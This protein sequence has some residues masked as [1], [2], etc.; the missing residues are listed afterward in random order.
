MAYTTI[1]KSSSFQ[2][3]KLYAGNGGTQTISGVGFQPNL[4]WF[5]NRSEA[6]DHALYDTVRGAYWTIQTNTNSTQ[7]ANDGLTSWTSD[8]FNIGNVNNTNKNGNNIVAWNWKAGTTSGLSGGTITPTSYSIN[9]T[10][11]FGIYKYTG[12]NTSG[13]TI[14]HGLG[15]VPTLIFIKRYEST[16]GSWQVLGNGFGQPGPNSY[17]I[18]NSTDGFASNA[19]RWNNT[20]PTTSLFSL[21]NSAEV[22]ASGG[23][24]IAYVWCNVSGYFKSG[25]YQG[26]GN[27]DG[28]FVYTGGSPTFTIMRPNI[29]GKNWYMWDDKRN[30]YNGS[31]K[32]NYPNTNGAEGDIST[33]VNMLSNGFK[34][35]TTDN[36]FNGLGNSYQYWCWMQTLVGTNNVPATAR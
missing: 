1:N 5:K 15:A 27:A 3:T 14:S 24:Y 6:F 26:N 35:I 22:N 18:L 20:A 34:I 32:F 31:L 10:S 21:G 9:T 17:G 12:N 36:S 13:A 2:D 30:G 4:T 8:G 33:Y 19:N 11:K 28:P 23:I 7:T 16:T 25:L 29:A